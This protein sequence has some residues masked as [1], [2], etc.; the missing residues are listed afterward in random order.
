MPDSLRSIFTVAALLLA[1]LWLATP[2]VAWK[3]HASQHVSSPVSVDQHHHHD[4]DG[5]PVDERQAPSEPDGPGH[6]HMPSGAASLTATVDGRPELLVPDSA[7][8][9]PVRG[10]VPT[11]HE[12]RRPPPSEPPRFS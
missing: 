9:A 3:V 5:S 8:V 4:A 7:T 12:L 6:D 1:G 10:I 11:L 2:A